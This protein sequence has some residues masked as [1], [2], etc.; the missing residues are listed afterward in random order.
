ME[1]LVGP[2]IHV[3]GMLLYECSYITSPGAARNEAERLNSFAIL[4]AIFT[5]KSP[6]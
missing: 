5:A 6:A 4:L 3:V 1:F 2:N